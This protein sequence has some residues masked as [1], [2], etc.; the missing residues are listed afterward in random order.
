MQSKTSK[1]LDQ[2]AQGLVHFQKFS[3]TKTSQP[4]RVPIPAP[5]RGE[6][7]LNQPAI[8]FL[9]QLIQRYHLVPLV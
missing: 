4:L 9:T 1:K 6:K 3:K 8:L 2:V 7:S 5:A